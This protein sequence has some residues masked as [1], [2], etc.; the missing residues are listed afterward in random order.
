MYK[1]LFV[2]CITLLLVKW[3]KSDTYLHYPRGSN[4]RL[5]E[6]TANRANANRLFDSQVISSLLK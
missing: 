5:N 6:D 1:L 4:N 3:V 2:F